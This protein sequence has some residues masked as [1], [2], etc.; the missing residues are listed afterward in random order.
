MIAPTGTELT[1]DMAI[2]LARYLFGV[3][4]VCMS[5]GNILRFLRYPSTK[6]QIVFDEAV[7][8]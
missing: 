3:F 1:V 4:D 8:L 2:Q 6:L 5:L 7:Q